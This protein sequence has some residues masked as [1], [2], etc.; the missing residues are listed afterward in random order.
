MCFQVRHKETK[1]VYAM[2]KL[3]KCAMVSQRLY[4]IVLKK[5]I[6][7]YKSHSYVSD[8]LKVYVKLHYY[9]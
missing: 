8:T 2:K 3:N 7:L 1:Q 5:R 4:E 6:L 9:K